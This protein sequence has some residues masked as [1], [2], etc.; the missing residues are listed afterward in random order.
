[1][2]DQSDDRRKRVLV[3][4]VRGQWSLYLREALGSYECR[5]TGSDSKVHFVTLKTRWTPRSREAS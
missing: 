4:S 5:Y 2:H 1:M 3:E